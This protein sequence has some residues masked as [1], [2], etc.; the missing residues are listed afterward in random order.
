MAAIPPDASLIESDSHDE[1]YLVVH[2]LRYFGDR[3][4]RKAP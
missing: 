1:R 4:A 2:Y 3:L